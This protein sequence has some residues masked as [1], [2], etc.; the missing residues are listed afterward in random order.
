MAY[1]FQCE[2]CKTKEVFSIPTFS[3]KK[4]HFHKG[5]MQDYES[6]ICTG[7][8]SQKKRLKGNYII[9]EKGNK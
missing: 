1:Y 6:V 3:E 2:T 8:I 9:I 4:V 5:K 7:C